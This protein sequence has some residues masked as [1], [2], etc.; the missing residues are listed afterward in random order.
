M[1]VIAWCGSVA[2][3]LRTLK[4]SRLEG[5]VYESIICKGTAMRRIILLI[6]FA[7]SLSLS[8][9][10]DS[11]QNL[12][13]VNWPWFFETSTLLY[14]GAFETAE[15]QLR[16]AKTEASNF[17]YEANIRELDTRSQDIVVLLN[18]LDLRQ[19]QYLEAQRPVPSDLVYLITATRSLYV[20]VGALRNFYS[21]RKDKP[22]ALSLELLYL[23]ESSYNTHQL[24]YVLFSE[25]KVE[26]VKR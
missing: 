24:A 17:D 13:E 20:G 18:A 8:Q 19:Q 3:V 11:A 4:P 1:F 21:Q 22:D 23:A 12:V 16:V 26:G 6:C 10:Q 14:F 2:N 7:L 15:G 5:D 9:A 25:Q